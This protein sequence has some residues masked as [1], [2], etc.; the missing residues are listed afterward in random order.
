[1]STISLITNIIFTLNVLWF[2]VAF[3]YFSLTPDTAARL[4]VP[5]S[6]RESPLFSTVSASVRFLG[7]MNFA[8]AAFALLLLLNRGLFPEAKQ[9]ALFAAVFSIAH[10]S[11]FA[12]NVPVA[13]GG[14][15]KGESLWPVLTGPMF[16]IF[17][18]DF[19]LMIANGVL[20]AFLLVA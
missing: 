1:M 17:A 8:F 2:G 18:T 16:F 20:A 13:L 10:A 14:G 12:F 5:K 9:V 3:R 11:Q 6:A 19:T 4:L 15:R 7:G